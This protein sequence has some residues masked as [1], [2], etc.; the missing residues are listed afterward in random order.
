[1]ELYD[2]LGRRPSAFVLSRCHREVGSYSLDLFP[3]FVSS[4]NMAGSW[5]ADLCLHF[6]QHS[7]Q[8]FLLILFCVLFSLFSRIIRA[9]AAMHPTSAKTEQITSVFLS[10]LF[11]FS[12]FLSQELGSG[13]LV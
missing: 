2:L 12:I 8:V 5:R 10:F 11:S 3:F 9:D 1:V 4:H 6:Q 7:I 13:R